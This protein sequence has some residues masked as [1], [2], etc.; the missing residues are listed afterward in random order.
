MN[1]HTLHSGPWGPL[2]IGW[3]DDALVSIG[4]Y[5]E[6]IPCVSLS[7]LALEAAQ[8]LDEYIQGRRTCFDLPIRLR[9]TEFQIAVWNAL[10]QIPYG[11]V[12]TYGQIA[13]AIGNPKAARAVGQA[14]NRNPL[15]LL[16]PC[17]RVVGRDGRLTGYA[18]GLA[19]KQA[20]LELEQHHK[21]TPEAP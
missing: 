20:L 6:D 11:E 2:L 3:E 16:V 5:R 9:G 1:Y 10:R 21:S 15:W 7:L 19:M 8:Q 4:P 12:R 17:H 13:E 14:A 18:G